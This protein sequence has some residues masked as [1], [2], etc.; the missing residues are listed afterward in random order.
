M[1]EWL[2]GNLFY[3]ETDVRTFIALVR[4]EWRYFCDVEI[5]IFIE[6]MYVTSRGKAFR[7]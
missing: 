6:N 3:C 4:L 2:L 7:E 1:E 5:E